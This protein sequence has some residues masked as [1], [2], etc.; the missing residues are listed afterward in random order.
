MGVTIW[1]NIMHMQFV[2]WHLLKLEKNFQ[3]KHYLI[4][5]IFLSVLFIVN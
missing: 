5:M 1:L 3:V 4:H 2:F